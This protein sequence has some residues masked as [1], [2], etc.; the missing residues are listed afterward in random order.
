MPPMQRHKTGKTSLK[1]SMRTIAKSLKG[2]GVSKA[3][4]RSVV[5]N[6]VLKR[7]ETEMRAKGK[8]IY[9]HPEFRRQLFRKHGKMFSAADAKTENG[10]RERGYYAWTIGKLAS[11]RPA[12]YAETALKRRDARIQVYA[13]RL[14]GE[15]GSVKSIPLIEPLTKS[16]DTRV[17]EMAEKVLKELNKLKH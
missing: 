17:A 10:F 5:S 3:H 4:R 14:L 12:Y 7:M 13:I 8:T 16:S 15:L 1:T 9:Q 2:A 6:S 11:K